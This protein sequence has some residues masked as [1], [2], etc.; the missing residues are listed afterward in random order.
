MKFLIALLAVALAFVGILA[1]SH[2]S[3][4]PD[5]LSGLAGEMGGGLKTGASAF[6][7]MF[8]GLSVWA[9]VLLGLAGL[10]F[11]VYMF[12]GITRGALIGFLALIGVAAIAALTP[13]NTLGQELSVVFPGAETWPDAIRAKLLSWRLQTQIAAVLAV[14]AIVLFILKY[15]VA[16]GLALV[17]MVVA[18]WIP[19]E[20]AEKWAREMSVGSGSSTTTTSTSVEGTCDGKPRDIALSSSLK[21]INGGANCKMNW[22][23]DEPVT[24]AERRDGKGYKETFTRAGEFDSRVKFWQCGSGNS[25][26]VTAVFC[27]QTTPWWDGKLNTCSTV[28]PRVASR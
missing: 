11:A 17:A 8:W 12:G 25:C 10:A 21:L 28:K 27:P 16:G 6:G 19:Q 15:K 23:I 4:N 3:S 20:M 18:F 24:L 7:Q 13:L 22:G 14:V 2:F 9:R 26:S 5:A 1:F